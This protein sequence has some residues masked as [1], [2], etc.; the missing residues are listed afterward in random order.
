M[1]KKKK[2]KP[3]ITSNADNTAFFSPRTDGEGKDGMLLS[4]KSNIS[5]LRAANIMSPVST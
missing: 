5:N 4:P 2:K 1:K 3:T